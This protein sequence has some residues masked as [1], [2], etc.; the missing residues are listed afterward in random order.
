MLLFLLR[1]VGEGAK[2]YMNV[3]PSH[4]TVS[5][6]H[7]IYYPQHYIQFDLKQNAYLSFSFS[8][9]YFFVCRP[10][11]FVIDSPRFAIVFIKTPP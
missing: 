4:L 11:V 2:R 7:S 8:F 9:L 5:C 6:F 1:F 10:Y 3:I